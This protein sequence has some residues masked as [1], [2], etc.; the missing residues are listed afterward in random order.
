M[1]QG[2]S[3]PVFPLTADGRI[4]LDATLLKSLRKARGL[5]QEA[6]ADACFQRQLAVSIASVKRAETGRAVLYR[7]ARQLA[8]FYDVDV[9]ALVVR[10]DGAEQTAAPAAAAAVP[11]IRDSAPVRHVIELHLAH[12]L[13]PGADTLA[14]IART[15]QQF[16]GRMAQADG[17]TVVALF[18]LPQSY[19]SDAERSLR[20]AAELARKHKVHGTQALALRMV[21]WQ[22]DGGA[23]PEAIEGLVNLGSARQPAAP[24]FVAQPLAFQL[25]ARAAFAAGVQRLPGYMQVAEALPALAAPLA[26]RGGELRQFM[27]IVE[28]ALENQAGHIAYL[29][30][31]AGVGKSRLVQE[32][33][34]LARRHGFRWHGCDIQ[35]TGAESWRAPL[36]QLARS[37]FD[38]EPGLAD[39]LEQV[40]DE[41]IAELHLPADWNIFYRALAGARMSPEQLSLYAAMS[42]TVR[43]HGVATA[44]R[45][46]LL[47][48]AESEPLLVSVEDLHWGEPTFFEALAGLLALSREAPIVWVLSSRIEDDPLEAHLR[49]HLFDVALSTFDLAPLA[50]REAQQLADQFPDID[51]AL[52]RRCVERAQGNPLFLTQLLASPGGELPD[53]LKHL[54]QA[55]LDA[56]APQHR[57]ALRT[58][59]VF[60]NRFELALL[61]AIL[62]DM[63][64]EPEAAGRNSM[65]RRMAPGQYMFVHDL[66]M[67]CIYESIEQD[68]VR[69]LHGEIAELY[70]ERDPAL[71]AQHLYRAADP[72]AFEMML[73]AI[74]DKLGAHQYEDALDLCAQCA[75]ADS[76]R[77]SSFALALLKAHATAGMGQMALARERYEHSLLL[78]GRPQEKI[79][80]VI[81]LATALN[82]LDLLDEEER[83]IN[84]TLPLAQAINAEASLGKL[85]YLKGNIYFPRGNY[86]ECRRNHEE[87]VRYA[88]ASGMAE[89]E[90]RALS[91]LGD[92]YYAEGRMQQAHRYFAECIDM[93]RRHGM[94]NIEASNRSALGSTSLYLGR[95]AEAVTEALASARIAHQVGN[96]RAEVVARMTA[97]WVHAATGDVTGAIGQATQGLELARTIGA[98]RFEPFLM[99][100][101][102]RAQWLD[103]DHG[104]ARATIG[105]AAEAVE[106]QKLHRYIGPWVLGTLALFTD[107]PAIR[108]RAL[109]Q[110]AAHLTRDC[111]AHNAYRFHLAAAEIA[112]LDGDAITAE[113]HAEQLEA[114]GAEEPCAWTAHHAALLRAVAAGAPLARLLAE[115]GQ[116]G[117]AYAAPR[118]HQSLPP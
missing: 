14:G 46:L 42:H 21:R 84:E 78:A 2:S 68:Q 4:A 110:G 24:I 13:V 38:L 116:S 67:H 88:R 82:V 25:A 80:A 23:A 10:Q 51:P 28:T 50:A 19:R 33:A 53:T 40:I 98:S 61:R 12:A 73:R 3:P 111:L 93:C 26:G 70:R 63:D 30:G 22:D 83:R 74:R 60:G 89:T 114:L 8:A 112:L 43:D 103:G 100:T 58:A 99:E 31:P 113:F 108:K 45:M 27:A 65:V 86:A 96:R 102:A 49:P 29:R 36:E 87:A 97:G 107:D 101:L 54:V 66:V 15:V 39:P 72:N 56:M 79:D 32:Y 81:G 117:F 37:L 71:S 106:R 85:M 11:A 76:T 95:P 64:Y 16:G 7:T 1:S 6:L 77:Y 75:A 41:V 91:G 9:D 47:R 109:L 20:C 35:D 17:R 104:A 52:R 59:S 105:A 48:R 92:S 5:S 118:L 55:R 34:A 18:G 115:G 94:L 90:A 62:G 57:A 44:L 69:R